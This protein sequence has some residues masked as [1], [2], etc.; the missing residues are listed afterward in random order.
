[1]N[2]IYRLVNEFS[3]AAINRKGIEMNR[4]P[5]GPKTIEKAAKTE[6]GKLAAAINRVMYHA[7]SAEICMKSR[8]DSNGIDHFETRRHKYIC[9][10]ETFKNEDPLP[11]GVAACH[12]RQNYFKTEQ[13]L[14]AIRDYLEAAA[15]REVCE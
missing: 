7:G 11:K 13:L 1:M 9:E 5:V 2:A 12:N 4:Y 14:L 8:T 10:V 3:F 6:A 15:I